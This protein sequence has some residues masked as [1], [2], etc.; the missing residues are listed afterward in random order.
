MVR[1]NFENWLC[2]SLQLSIGRAADYRECELLDE[3]KTN[4]EMKEF[5]KTVEL[6]GGFLNNTQLLRIVS[7]GSIKPRDALYGGNQITI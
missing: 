3:L 2:L 1:S 7:L 6:K 4:Q 5:F